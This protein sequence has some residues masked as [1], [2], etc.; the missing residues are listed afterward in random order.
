MT[1]NTPSDITI[2]VKDKG[3]ILREKSLIAIS[4][5]KIIAYGNECEQMQA[6]HAAG[7]E[8][9]TVLSPFKQNKIIDFDCAVALLKYFVQKA[10]NKKRSFKRLIIGI[11]LPNDFTPVDKRIYEEVIY[12]VSNA[13][14]C[15]V[16]QEPFETIIHDLPTNPKLKKKI[17]IIIG[18][19]KNP[20]EYVQESVSDLLTFCDK[21]GI[22]KE[23]V[24][25]LLSKDIS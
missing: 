2:Y 14:Q 9:I 19:E 23:N 5:N 3:I 22:S 16:M 4:G 11:T 13:R 6:D 17:D 7:Q 10:R 20:L 21:N 18:I 24:I 8:D 15:Y 25:E 1:N 12:M